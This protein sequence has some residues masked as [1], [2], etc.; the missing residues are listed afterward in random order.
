MCRLLHHQC[1]E[2]VCFWVA[3]TFWTSATWGCLRGIHQ[4]RFS[5]CIHFEV[6]LTTE[7]VNFLKKSRFERRS[8]QRETNLMN[9]M[10][11]AEVLCGEPAWSQGGR[12]HSLHNTT[13]SPD[14]EHKLRN[15]NS[16]LTWP[17][18]HPSDDSFRHLVS[19]WPARDQD[20]QTK[21]VAAAYR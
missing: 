20:P 6:Y 7:W 4:L 14:Q 11:S 15:Q 5:R 21:M 8:Q 1:F 18:V 10:L 9:S 16:L 3:F 2:I 13:K 19:N 12:P 17:G